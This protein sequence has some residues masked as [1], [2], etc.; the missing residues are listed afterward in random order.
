VTNFVS[1]RIYDL[2][3]VAPSDQSWLEG[4]ENGVTPAVGTGATLTHEIYN[5]TT[6]A[7]GN[8][9][10]PVALTT[11]G[12]VGTEIAS[13]NL[14]ATLPATGDTFTFSITDAASLAQIE[15]WVAGGVNGGFVILARGADLSLGDS[16]FWNVGSSE[17]G[18]VANR[19][20]L[21][22]N[23]KFSTAAVLAAYDFEN[24]GLNSVDT[25]L[26]SVA[27]GI[28]FA[29]GITSHGVAGD[30]G[31]TNVPSF[32]SGTNDQSM[33]FQLAQAATSNAADARNANDYFTFTLTA[34]PGQLLDLDLLAFRT[35]MSNIA[36]SR[37][38]TLDYSIDGGDFVNDFA[39]GTFSGPQTT[40]SNGPIWT[41]FTVDLSAPQFDSVSSITF[42]LVQHGGSNSTHA[43]YF[44]KIQVTGQALA[45]P[46]PSTSLLFVL[47]AIAV[48]VWHMH[49]C[50]I[51][52]N[53]AV[54]RRER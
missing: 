15:T 33:F 25:N 6:W 54:A 7:G 30:R 41:P 23:G 27:G 17:A 36:L 19:P 40:A 37:T 1:S 34:N 48:V 11:S 38:W 50:S 51:F 18:I 32:V 53:I 20:Q 5:T 22:L 42:R 31:E 8:S 14:G 26:N 28:V 16:P 46:E 4:S 12:A 52:R 3:L 39:T 35:A 43:G 10:T 13:I 21:A 44:D 49:D 9:R 47:A 29:N 24:A 2:F 45:V